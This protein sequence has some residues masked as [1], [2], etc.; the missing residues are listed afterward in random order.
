MGSFHEYSSTPRYDNTLLTWAS[1]HHRDIIQ[2]KD[3]DQSTSTN[4]TIPSA[5]HNR[6]NKSSSLP[7]RTCRSPHSLI[8]FNLRNSR[9][10]FDSSAQPSDATPLHPSFPPYTSSP[11]TSNLPKKQGSQSATHEIS[12]AGTPHP[13]EERRDGS[14][15]F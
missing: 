15:R 7:L 14:P 8:R 3:N 9:S 1:F 11:K 2:R 5:P 13:C 10:P 6:S 4:D 12:L